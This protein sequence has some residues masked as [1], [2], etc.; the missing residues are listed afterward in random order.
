MGPFQPPHTQ[1]RK[2]SLKGAKHLSQHRQ[3]FRQIARPQNRTERKKW[4]YN[5]QRKKKKEKLISFLTNRAI[6]APIR[7]GLEVYQPHDDN[8][9][10]DKR[11]FF[12]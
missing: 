12:N 8:T 1:N 2:E 7:N 6:K 5:E 3:H 9:T 4:Y 10:S 11:R